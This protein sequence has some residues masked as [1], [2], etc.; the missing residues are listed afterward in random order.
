MKLA[1]CQINNTVGD[2]A[3]NTARISE[4]A[5]RAAAAGA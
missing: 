1:L 4:F 5:A 3:G 2:L